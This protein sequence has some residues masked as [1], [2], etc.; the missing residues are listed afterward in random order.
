[1]KHLPW[2]LG[3]L[4]LAALNGFLVTGMGSGPGMLWSILSGGAYGLVWG[5]FTCD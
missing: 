5:I 1:V 2:I 3:A 4:L